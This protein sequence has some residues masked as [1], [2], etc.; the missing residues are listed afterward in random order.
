MTIII[1]NDLAQ[2]L[3]ND[4]I[5]DTNARVLFS[6]LSGYGKVDLDGLAETVGVSHEAVL[7]SMK[8]L[9]EAGFIPSKGVN[10]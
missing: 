5:F 3:V 1:S 6:V 9:A 8:R 4:P 7:E 2:A 10:S